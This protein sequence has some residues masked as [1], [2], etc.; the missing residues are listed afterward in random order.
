MTPEHGAL[1][2]RAVAAATAVALLSLLLPPLAGEAVCALIVVAAVVLM[3][4]RRRRSNPT[5]RLMTVGCVLIGMAPVVT[6]IHRA[7]GGGDLFSAGDATAI[8]GY[9]F[10][11]AAAHRLLR[12]RTVDRQP[13]VVLDALSITAWLALLVGF[14]TI[15]D[16]QDLYTGAD[17]AFVLAYVPFTLLMVFV[18]LRL[19][20]GAGDRSGAFL[21]LVAAATSA[22]I[23]EILFLESAVGSDAA[24]QW[25]VVVA[26]LALVFFTA[27]FFHPSADGLEEPHRSSLGQ[28]SNLLAGAIGSSTV[29]VVLIAFMVDL[30]AFEVAILAFLG[31]VTAAR[32]VLVVRERDE[33][34]GLQRVVADYAATVADLDDQE[35]ILD[36]GVASAEVMLARKRLSFVAL[37][38]HSEIDAL[39]F[40]QSDPAGAELNEIDG[41]LWR[42]VQSG[43]V[44]RT[45]SSN[46]FARGHQSRL[47]IPIDSG[48]G[49][50]HVMAVESSPVL[51]MTEVLHLE[52]LAASIGRAIAVTDA[53]HR[54][55]L[56]RADR[57]FRSLVQD[58]NDVVML[59]DAD[60]FE[61][62]LVSPTVERLLGY[63]EAECLG[64]HP[65]QFVMVEDAGRLLDSLDS[66]AGRSHPLDLRLVRKNEQ[67]RWF[68]ATVRLLSDDE[69]SGYIVS[70]ADIHDRKMAELQLGTSE[71]R[72]RSLVESSREIFAVV[73]DQLM[74]SYVSPNVER[75]LG[76]P[77]AAIVGSNVLDVVAA[78]SI[79]AARE[80]VQLPADAADGRT[81]ELQLLTGSDST[82]WFEVSI[83]ERSHDDDGWVLTA[84]DVH[85]R[86]ELQ[87]S[88]ER[89]YLHDDLTGLSNRSS[90]QFE[91]NQR[92]QSLGPDELVGVLHLDVRDF[93]IVNESLGFEVGDQLLVAIAGRIRS[94]LR[95]GDLLARF[96]ADSFGV[97]TTVRSV[98]VLDTIAQRV[99]AMFDE[100]FDIVGRQWSVAMSIG[101]ASTSDRRGA[102]VSLLED[103]ALA[104]RRAKTAEDGAPV[105]F[106][107]FMREIAHERFELESDLLPGLAAGEF[108]VVFQPLLRLATQQVTS[109]E[110]LLRWNHPERGP[111]SPGAFIPVAEH[112][113]AIV[114][115]GRWVLEES[116]RQLGI[117]HRELPDATGLGVSVNLSVRQLVKEGEFER[118]TRIILDS[119]VDP[120]RVSLELTE[121][122]VINEVPLV[123][124]GIEE[125]RSLGIRIAVD[126]FGTGTA[127]LNHLRDVPFDVLKID[128]SYVDPL[129]QGNDSYQLLASVVELAH[130]M[131]ATVVAE[132]IETSEQAKLL[133]HMGCDLGQGFY[134][135]RPMD[136]G[137]LEGWFAAGREG[138][139]AAQIVQPIA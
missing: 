84:R 98:D 29:V 60:T 120:S 44:Q 55:Q 52:L 79:E 30:R 128:K 103:A 64:A 12:L 20:I 131:G 38:S 114:E 87:Q 116:C 8:L 94:A 74:L 136:P 11:I 2:W 26:T 68:A 106:E 97:L 93:K 50:R 35:L 111:V 130:S 18:I 95:Q 53:R 78:D 47:V 115:L 63:S 10:T 91:I 21:L 71:R 23:S 72:Y 110:A 7:V 83:N 96:G 129:A 14:M 125:M 65:L 127:G 82:R 32:S 54:G 92:L 58:S 75:V 34:L 3:I 27:A 86:R 90:F 133:R 62:K 122:L 46:S 137:G 76:V 25:G 77:A 123:R 22:V 5:I 81:I 15:E 139:V 101:L 48:T 66:A 104:V 39:V 107:P 132:G 24:R 59:V 134:L 69:L 57:R 1:F 56:E 61:T 112:S 80:L 85:A 28:T 67:I 102:A 41:D 9:L 16:V 17:E 33:W 37:H 51:S 117:W 88:M 36:Q 119:G 105:S 108:F 40:E 6:E 113:G 19:S 43:S 109:V 118:L 13:H 42:A 70:L 138:T 4:R 124:R 100:P 99:D 135:A 73:N 31:V 126:D 121:S 45:E 49:E 89:S